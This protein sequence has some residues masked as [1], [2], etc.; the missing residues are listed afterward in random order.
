[1]N[2][3]QIHVDSYYKLEYVRP[4]I[5]SYKTLSSSFG[6][7]L[8]QMFVII[9]FMFKVLFDIMIWLFNNF[10]VDFDE[11]AAG[12]S[13]CEQ[14]CSNSDGRFSCGCYFGYRLNSDRR[15]CFIGIQCSNKKIVYIS[16]VTLFSSFWSKEDTDANCVACSLTSTFSPFI[17]NEGKLN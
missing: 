8:L 9:I 15:T 7:L 6:L 5:V 10:L 13:G 2:K 16:H 17:K 12:V 3:K 11:C 14:T 1:L 4:L